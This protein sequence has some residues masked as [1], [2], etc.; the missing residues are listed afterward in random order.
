M[1]C[2]CLNKFLETHS[3]R[4]HYIFQLKKCSQP[5]CEFG[6][7]PVLPADV[8][9][10]LSWLPDPVY[11][12]ASNKYLPF[13]DV[14]GREPTEKDRPSLPIASD[15]QHASLLVLWKV[16]QKIICIHVDQSFHRCVKLKTYPLFAKESIA[17]VP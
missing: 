2:E 13:Q 16:L 15:S 6:C 3:I 9:S 12:S 17:I 14:Y 7:K 10:Q 5:D 4:H 8:L 11:S 1:K